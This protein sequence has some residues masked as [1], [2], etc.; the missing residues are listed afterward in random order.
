MEVPA[1][2]RTGVPVV[3]LTAAVLRIITKRSLPTRA[4][5]AVDSL[6]ESPRRLYFHRNPQSNN[7]SLENYLAT[8][9]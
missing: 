2:V 3:D 4:T 9:D 8:R 5:G 6:K 7:Q 1:E